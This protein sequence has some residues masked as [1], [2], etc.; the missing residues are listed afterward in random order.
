M[1]LWLPTLVFP[2]ATSDDQASTAA[3]ERNTFMTRIVYSYGIAIFILSVVSIALI[4]RNRFVLLEQSRLR[5]R[6]I[7]R[8][9]QNAL[10]VTAIA[11]ELVQ[12][13]S[14]AFDPAV[15]WDDTDELPGFIQWL[16]RQG[17]TRFGVS[18][19]SEL[20]AMGILLLLLSWFL[21]L[22]CANKFQD[23]SVL[24]HRVLTKDLPAL[25]N[26]F[27]Y[28]GTI[29][30]FFSFLAC[31]DCSTLHHSTVKKCVSAPQAPPFLIAHPSISC[32]TAAHQWYALLG[33]WGITFF[34]P[35]GLLAHGMSQVLFQRE[36]LDI[37]YAPVLLLVTQLVKAVA[38]T[39]QAFFP[40]EPLV[41][42]S[43]GFI[44]NGV[45]LALTLT[46]HSCSLWYIKYV[47]CSVYAASCWAS[48]GAVH[49]LHNA[50][51]SSTRSLNMIYLGWL[52]IGLATATAI[53]WRVWRR[54]RAKQREDELRFAA[55]QRLLNAGTS[56]GTLG[57]VGQ[58][59]MK[60][61]KKH[62]HDAFTR[63]VFV[64]NATRLSAS[65]PPP[66]LKD[67]MA[68]AEEVRSCSDAQSGLFMQNARSLATKLQEQEGLRRR[69]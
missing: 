11:V 32:W 56:A 16:G 1:A 33:L 51:E 17:I 38:A 26:G 68:R 3:S 43:L 49:R 36:T 35:I 63:A 15:D 25:V 37:K 24:L 65:A 60:A 2:T 4:A 44:G 18:S 27:F 14:L 48:L 21:L 61:A 45:L 42:A 29:S 55:Q 28:M 52:S 34:L 20:Q 67:F 6:P 30:A 41:L 50:G 22:K 9:Y 13:N 19:A 62:S 47:K 10:A 7:S 5:L 69:R 66:A 12:L 64:S 46:M 59:F 58:K 31:V 53:L 54:A 57:A 40:F 23:T 39:A 8:Y